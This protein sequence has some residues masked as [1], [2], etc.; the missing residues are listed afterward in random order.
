MI[1]RK[2]PDHPAGQICER[3]QAQPRTRDRPCLLKKYEKKIPKTFQPLIEHRKAQFGKPQMMKLGG[4]RHLKRRK[5]GNAQTNA[6]SN[7][8][9]E[10]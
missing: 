5:V 10:V 1:R 2:F 6:P 7:P 9:V 3:P 8:L 4:K